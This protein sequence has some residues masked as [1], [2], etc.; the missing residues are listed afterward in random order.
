MK[1][2][3]KRKQETYSKI[4]RPEEVYEDAEKFYEEVEKYESGAMKKTQTEITEILIEL[5]N[6]EGNEKIL[7]VG[8]GTGLSMLPFIER[9]YEIVGIEPVEKMIKWSKEKNKE[10]QKNN[11]T[12]KTEKKIEIWQGGFDEIEEIGTKILKE[13]KWKNFDII[14]SVS[15]L[16]WKTSNQQE[17]WIKNYCNQLGKKMQKLLNWEENKKSKIGIQ[18]YP[19]TKEEIEYVKKGFEKSG[20]KVTH[21]TDKEGTKKEKNYLIIN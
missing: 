17:L 21:Y 7:D 20:M 9:K 2:K 1:R 13:K 16:Q 8:A 10:L 4:S 19:K 12:E 15:A 6:L 14:I 18:F 3:E 5:L 11:A